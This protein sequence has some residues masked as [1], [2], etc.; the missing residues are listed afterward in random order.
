MHKQYQRS[1]SEELEVNAELFCVIRKRNISTQKKLKK[2]QKLLGKNP[3]PD[4]NAQDSSD[5]WNTSLHLAIKR[6]E[7]E[8]VNFLLTQGADTAI[9]NGDGKT[10]LKLA[11]ELNHLEIIEALKSFPSQVEWPPS[12]TDR[13]A[14]HS[15]QPDAD[16]PNQ[17]S[18]FH[19]NPN[20]A[21]CRKQIASTVLPPFSG[22]LTVDKDLNFSNENFKQ[23]IK[24]VHENKQLSTIDQLKATPPYPT[25]QVLAQFANMVYKDCSPEKPEPPHGWKFLTA[26]SHFGKKN[27]Y[28]GAAY[29]HPERQQ[30]VIAHRGTDVKNIGALVTDLKGVLFNNYVE[31]MNSAST[32]A[33]KVVSVLQEIEQENKV[34]FEQFFTGHSLGGW[35]AQVTA[36]TTEYLEV[37]EDKFL[38]RLAR[39]EHEPSASNTVQDSHGDRQSCHPH[40]VVFDSP[41][42]K[43]MLSQM[44]DKLD[45]RL[46]GHSVDLQ[47]LD[48]TSYLSA[49]NRINTC[50]SHL[51]TVYRIFTDL[52]DMG[53]KEKRTLLYNLATHSMDKIVQAFDPETGQ[54]RK[55]DKGRLKI[56]EVVDWPVSAGLTG[57]G[58]LKDFFKW[59]KHLN[60]YHAEI[61]DIVPNKVPKGYHPLRYQTK[62]YDECTESLRIFKQ[63]QREFLERY[64]W[65]CQVEEFFQPEDL[66]SV[67]ND[68]EAT[69][70]AE[71]K[72][73]N[74]ELANESVRCPDTCTL[75]AL[76]PYVKRLVRLFPQIKENIKAKLSSPQI[77]NRVYQ[78]ETGCY[79]KI[80]EQNALDFKREALGLKEFLTS[81][82]QV[83][84]L[85]MVDGDV[86]TGITKVYRVLQN[87]S[88]MAD[89]TRKGHYTILKLKRLLT[90]NRMINLNALLESIKTPHLL[91]IAC[92][93]NEPVN[94][95]L[96]TIFKELF[97]IMK[98]RKSMK[99]IVTTQ[100]EDSTAAF[101]EQIASK[102]FVEGFLT[103]DEHLTW[104]DLTSSSQTEI[105][106]KTVIFQGKRVALNQ[107]T[108][109]QSM[110]DSFPLADLLQE[111]ELRISEEPA[112]SVCNGY[113]K[114]YYIDRTFNHSIVIKQGISRD[115]RE[116]KF[117]DL[118]VSNEQ[119]F[120]NLCKQN[121]KENVHW[122]EIEK[123]GELIWRQSH[124]NFKT[125]H[126]YI[127]THKSHSYAP[128]DLDN[129][130]QEATHQRVMLI[131]DNA[132]MGKSTVLTHLSKQIA[133]KFPAHW[134]VRTD[135]NDYTEQLRALKGKQMDKGTVLEFVS[136]E[137]LKLHSH[138]EKE[139]FKKSFEGN[140]VNKV[141][142]M[143]DGF[144]EIS[145]SYKETVIDMLQVLKQTSL[146]QLWVTTRPHLREEL[147]DNLQQLSY[148]LQP[149]SE[150][151]QVEFLKKFW[152]QNSN[153]EHEDEHR[154]EIYATALI[155][156]LAQSISDKDR[157]F[158]GIPLQT[159]MLAEAFEEDFR[160][161]YVSEKSEPELPHKLDLL[162][163][164]GRF[165][166]SKYEI[167]YKEK[168]KFQP[169]NMGADGVRE[170]D[171][172]NIQVV[173]QLLAL[174][175]L[176]TE[177]Q[178]TFLHGYNNSSFSD[179]D[180]A[181]IGIAQRNHEGKPHFIHRTFAEYF[182]ADFLINQLTKKTKQNTQ[183]KELLLNEVLLQK[184]CHVT[185]AFL[186]GLLGNSK[187]STE[188]LNEYGD[189]LD[190]QWNKGEVQ[191]PLIVDTTL[192]HEAATQDNAHIIGFL[193]DSLKSGEHSNALKLMLLAK[194]YDGRTAWHVAAEAGHI[195]VLEDM[196]MWVKA[197]LNPHEFLLGQDREERTV[198][199]RAAQMGRVQ[200]L[201]K[202][203][204][205]AKELQPKPDELRNELWLSKSDFDQTPWH[206]AAVE[207]HVEV[208][209]TLWDW[210]KELQ[211]KPEELKNEVLLSKGLYNK[212]AW[213]MAAGEGHI[214]VL[215]KL[216]E[217]AKELQLK[218]E[219]LRNEVW[220]SKGEFDQTAWH[221]AA[222]RNYVDVLQKL[223]D[224]AKELQLKPEELMNDVWCV[225][226]SSGETAWHMAAKGCN[227][228]V[229]EKL[230][231]WAKE[232]YKNPEKLKNEM[233]L[234]KDEIH[235]TAWHM[236][237]KEGYVEVL[238]KLWDLA[239]DLQLKPEELMNEV[240]SS[241]GEFDRTA[242]HLAT[243][244]GCIEV[245]E[246]LWDWAKKLQL[247]QEELMNEVL[248]SKGD[249]DRTAWHLAAVCGRVDIL[250]K[251]WNWAKELQL[252]PE[253][254][255]NDVW[256]S[257]DEFD[258]TAWH[259]AAGIGRSKIL[260][261][262]WDCAKELQLK[263]EELRNKVLWLKDKSG[264]TACHNAA[265]N[266]HVEVIE[267]L[268]DW[269][270][271][272]H[273]KTEE[274]RNEVWLS[275]DK[276]GR[277]ARHMAAGRGHVQVLYKLRDWAEEMQL[278]PNE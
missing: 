110:P 112:P 255:R 85:R 22:K 218:P 168:S 155:R 200:I 210:A 247:K 99:I 150:A 5:K 103:K 161:F 120:K 24:K 46:H 167:F 114:K 249:F 197:Q 102:E 244:S 217:W 274:F 44:A 40:T 229:L 90:V 236:A 19:S 242:W 107:L 202:L 87:T 235:Q 83:W 176:F 209:D 259:L 227:V 264:K 132:G 100:P 47:H 68:D 145:P 4:I 81:D 163:L 230:W 11:E 59:A 162:G 224:W 147:E 136:K 25:P 28:F 245:L 223:W 94:D 72:L 208:L 152:L 79:V 58:E 18:V 254:L 48:I 263:P 21:A 13:L 198:W 148:T 8:V 201:Q 186:N 98:Q 65:L 256:L 63:D 191:G 39:E 111:R 143:V 30:V 239:K 241:K 73:R 106:K 151:E 211:L 215:E 213:Q 177:D 84:Q 261:K 275:K 92:E 265:E 23:S 95:E 156:K 119:E 109:A 93:N 12:E 164:Y 225:K 237:A 250:E 238:E 129:L 246:K 253:E 199:H 196:W 243:G 268:W 80:I 52:S 55:D 1:N 78:H 233:W 35:L 131:A 42:C 192:L 122:L 142:V 178:V 16:N 130:L 157:E 205:W 38:K 108:S 272:L 86:W 153:L 271:E 91:M 104:N 71:L 140:E 185:R 2:V 226:N 277:T 66:F 101:L 214:E 216:W 115:K 173:H 194:D 60:N 258:Q 278:N 31:Q 273:I 221:K 53:W 262:L 34:S 195:K 203:W 33:K 36:F 219:E 113:N 127:D 82:Q 105:L 125:L 26:A 116:G 96:R 222:E 124:G 121:P 252:K 76:I 146:E 70:E 97:S 41:G 269:A 69:K 166:D 181:R 67:M 128:S 141:V 32:F 50:N 27:G 75:Y 158:T 234:L 170:R 138:L 135:L 159:R 10:P 187:P 118:L 184:D 62:P 220:L 172:K 165:I 17:V 189:L 231:D 49:P 206:L 7:L 251:L 180:L 175:A 144:D 270:K 248:L 54:V 232:L 160:S 137:V 134:L 174:E 123:S 37:K 154:L 190:K 133:Q 240:W 182:V 169:G 61:M 276:S 89:Y 45:V 212:T 179:E 56:R 171:L 74:F 183:V 204:E 117:A 228:E 9:E 6:N 14:S 57:G 257:K 20:V 207:G 149:F 126:E 77:R 260:Q 188:A 139:L 267:K 266:G 88:C 43:D 29:W 193:L 51:G 15:S 3:Q 64:H